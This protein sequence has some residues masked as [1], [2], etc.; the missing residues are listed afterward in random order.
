MSHLS[1]LQFPPTLHNQQPLWIFEISSALMLQ[2]DSYSNPIYSHQQ[3]CNKK[4]QHRE[5]IQSDSY[6]NTIYSYQQ[7]RN[8]KQQHRTNYGYSS[9]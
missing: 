8:N 6:S 9:P 2:S 1:I 5:P 3:L 4:Q 7:L